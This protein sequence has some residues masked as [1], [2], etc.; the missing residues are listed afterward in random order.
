MFLILKLNFK[1]TILTI[2]NDIKTQL[3]ANYFI[4]VFIIIKPFIIKIVTN[5]LETILM[6]ISH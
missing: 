1:L 2:L 6:L 4:L 3:N 5:V